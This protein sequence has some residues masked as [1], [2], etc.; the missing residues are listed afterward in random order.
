MA[1]K[2]LEQCSSKNGGIFATV[3]LSHTGIGDILRK[4]SDVITREIY[5]TDFKVSD[6]PLHNAVVYENAKPH[7][8]VIDSREADAPNIAL[9]YIVG[10]DTIGHSEL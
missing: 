1:N 8:M 5:S 7:V 3:G 2:L 9:E 6:S 4:N 10:A